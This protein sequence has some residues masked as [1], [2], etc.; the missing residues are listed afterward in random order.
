MALPKLNAIKYR[1]TI[2]SLQREVTYTPYNVR[3]EKNLMIAL[4]SNNTSQM[5][6]QLKTLIAECVDLG[7]VR[8][9]ELPTFDI[10]TIFLNL[11]CRSVGES[12]KV[13][14]KCTECDATNEL[15]LQ[16][17]NVS[18]T[19]ENYKLSNNVI[20]LDEENGIGVTLKY[21]TLDSTSA[22]DQDGNDL[23]NTI[24]M[25]AGCIE[26]IFTKD[27][28]FDC[29]NES[30]K[31]IIDFIESL[32]TEQFTKMA[33]FFADI[34]SVKMDVKFKCSK[35]GEENNQVVQGLQS[36]FT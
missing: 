29:K 34:P 4:E 16:L 33:E 13:G 18:M 1:M 9:D 7:D 14:V 26:S 32:N 28:V 6:E 30:Q 25:I 5:N 15:P 31:E 10:E 20:R 11:R 21:P 8:V 17:N 19:N 23:D 2:P 36:F 35:C 22:I 3:Q 24:A 27:E 12:I